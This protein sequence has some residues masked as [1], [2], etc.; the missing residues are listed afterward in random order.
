MQRLKSQQLLSNHSCQQVG[1]KILGSNRKKME[2]EWGNRKRMRK[3]R[4]WMRKWRE[5]EEM[6][7]EIG[8]GERFTL[9]IS[10]FS[11]Y[12]LPLYPFP[13]SKIVSFCR[14]MLKTALLLRMSQKTYHTRY[15]KIILGRIRCEKSPQVVRVCSGKCSQKV[16]FFHDFQL[17]IYFKEISTKHQH[18]D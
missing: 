13:L 6:E 16:A 2:R 9:Y 5:N 7:R 12:F 10:S 14:K 3:W 11:L 15:E 8:N 4:E 1:V 17:S 18:L